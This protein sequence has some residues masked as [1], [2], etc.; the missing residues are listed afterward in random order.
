MATWTCQEDI[1]YSNYPMTP[2]HDWDITPDG[3]LFLNDSYTAGYKLMI[4][5]IKPLAFVGAGITETIISLDSPFDLILSAQAALY[6]CQQKVIG[7]GSQ[8]TERW[9][10]L[11][12]FWRQ[13]L[14]QRKMQYHMVPPAGTLISGPG[15]TV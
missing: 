13:E 5:G 14:A 11:I 1:D 2:L 3:H 7:A 6:L 4:V 12:Q 9:Q 8:N 15:L 10:Q